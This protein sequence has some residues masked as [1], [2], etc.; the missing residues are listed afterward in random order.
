MQVRRSEL[1]RGAEQ[2]FERD[3]AGRQESDWF[4]LIKTWSAGK[5]GGGS[6]VA[7]AG[8]QLRALLLGLGQKSREQD[9]CNR[10]E[11]QEAVRNTYS[12]EHT[13]CTDGVA[14]GGG[15]ERE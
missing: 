12:A 4:V 10:D 3:V 5:I 14:G 8:E 7:A 11:M 15:V 1:Q 9:S 13:V 6:M 2:G